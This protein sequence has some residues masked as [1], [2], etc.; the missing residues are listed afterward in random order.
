MPSSGVTDHQRGGRNRRCRTPSAVSSTC[1]APSA[2]TVSA[3]PRII[4]SIFSSVGERA[5]AGVDG[6][7]EL[8]AGRRG[9]GQIGEDADDLRTEVVAAAFAAQRFAA[10]S[11]AS[12]PATRPTNS[13]VTLSA[14]A[15]NVSRW[16]AGLS[17]WSSGALTTGVLRTMTS[18]SPPTRSMSRPR[19]TALGACLGTVDSSTVLPVF[20][21]PTS[22]AAALHGTVIVQ[23]GGDVSD[24]RG[25]DALHHAVLRPVELR[26]G[27]RDGQERAW[28]SRAPRPADRRRWRRGA[29][30]GGWPGTRHGARC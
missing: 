27:L 5:V 20:S 8:Q 19:S 24:E 23:V 26:G 29:R 14:C 1:S 16:Q 11:S 10:A 22:P 18:R 13:P 21:G 3:T 28:R 2:T 9:T 30:S 12:G 7:R 15:V 6:G 17:T 25:V 4:A